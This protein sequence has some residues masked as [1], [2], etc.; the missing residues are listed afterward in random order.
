MWSIW[1]CS[2]QKQLV[3]RETEISAVLNKDE[4]S[5]ARTLSQANATPIDLQCPDLNTDS[6]KTYT[7]E[8]QQLKEIDQAFRLL[9]IMPLKLFEAE[10]E[11]RPSQT[12]LSWTVCRATITTKQTSIKT[13]IGYCPM[14][15][16]PATEFLTLF[17][18]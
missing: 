17:I 5:T 14:V 11:K 7:P 2:S 6:F 13:G 8:H 1:F 3:C 16:E 9:R 15:L 18:E 12:V 10:I 4:A